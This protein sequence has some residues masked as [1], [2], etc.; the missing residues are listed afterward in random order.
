MRQEVALRA[1]MKELDGIL[2]SYNTAPSGLW[3]SL[4]R[5]DLPLVV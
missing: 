4:G 5:N 1:D 3:K 2:V